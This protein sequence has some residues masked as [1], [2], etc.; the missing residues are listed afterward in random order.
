MI[1]LK[2]IFDR[3]LLEYSDKVKNQLMDKFTREK[4]GLRPS[5]IDY[6]IN[7]FDQ[8]KKNF[9]PENRD[10]LQ[11]SWEDLEQAIDS[12]PV[13]MK[14]PKPEGGKAIFE[15]DGVRVYRGT[16]KNACIKYGTGYS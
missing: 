2:N 3:V 13:K 6:Y 9:E 10:I 4:P 16:N 11:Y 15:D 1:K 14:A 8:I 5:T 12:Q 7:R